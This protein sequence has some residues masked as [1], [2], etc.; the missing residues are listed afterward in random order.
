MSSFAGW[1]TAC[2]AHY[3][4]HRYIRRAVDSLLSQSYPWIRVVVVNDGDPC[5][6]WRE[7]ASITDPRLLR[8]N[9]PQNGGCFF[10][11]EVTRRATPDPYFMMQDADDW[12]APN[13]AAKLLTSL[14]HSRSDL[15][16]S[17][18]PV[19]F[20]TQDGA[21]YP[22]GI[23]WDR[24][25]NGGTPA[26]FVV[27]KKI[28]GEFRYRAPHHGL[29]RTSAL[30]DIGGYYGGFRIGWDTL[31][32][33]LVLMIGSISWT[34]EP[35]YYRLIRPDSLTHSAD[36]GAQTEYAAAVTRCLRQ[37]YRECFAQYQSYRKG[38]ITRVGLSNSIQQICGRYI[39]SEARSALNFHARRLGR[40]MTCPGR[41]YG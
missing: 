5:P 33:N 30:R 16:V 20:E 8:F 26:R 10:C 6:P 27:Q 3:R 41:Q 28:S 40:E 35:L 36:T 1:V 19:F 23:R 38:E 17:S 4:C 12:A 11:W 39:T 34:P 21:P 13:R 9:L 29:I 7:L 22:A 25:A 24:V 2:I 15:A 31:L 32:T 14:L 18:Q 37:L